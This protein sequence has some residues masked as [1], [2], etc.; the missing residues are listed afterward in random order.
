MVV[1]H[2]SGGLSFKGR[3]NVLAN[4]AARA[5]NVFAANVQRPLEFS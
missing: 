4:S 3:G 1:S 2:A 5:V